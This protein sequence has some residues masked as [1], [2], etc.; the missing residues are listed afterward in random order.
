MASN[1]VLYLAPNPI[2]YVHC[3]VPKTR[4]TSYSMVIQNEVSTAYQVECLL[5]AVE[6]QPQLESVQPLHDQVKTNWLI[7]KI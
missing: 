6:L 4:N 1:Q 5:N 3:K 7:D 2:H